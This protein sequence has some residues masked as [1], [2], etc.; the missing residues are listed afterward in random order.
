MC[1]RARATLETAANAAAAKDRHSHPADLVHSVTR[2]SGTYVNPA[3][4][5]YDICPPPS[6]SSP[7]PPRCSQSE[8][9]WEL[10]RTSN[11][12]ESPVKPSLSM[13]LP[14]AGVNYAQLHRVSDSV[15]IASA[16]EVTTTP[17]GDSHSG[18]ERV[19]IPQFDSEPT[20]EFLIGDDGSIEGFGLRGIWGAGLGVQ[21]PTGE[22]VRERAEVWFDRCG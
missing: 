14:A 20:M 17:R 16:F 19:V 10:V 18:H 15:F 11:T 7:S 21:S 6:H 4:G 3:Y 13:V 9:Y 22:T 1:G 5:R 2:F 12:S 8:E